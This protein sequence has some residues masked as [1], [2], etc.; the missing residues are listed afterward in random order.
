MVRQVS[1]REGERTVPDHLER[2][3]P[4]PTSAYVS[5]PGEGLPLPSVKAAPGGARTGRPRQVANTPRWGV[6]EFQSPVFASCARIGVLG[7]SWVVCGVGLCS[8]RCRVARSRCSS[9]PSTPS[10]AHESVRGEGRE[11]GDIPVRWAV[12]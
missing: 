7:A 8:W 5:A 9:R 12:L 1:V 10:G 3:M 2:R 6:R 4:P 11:S